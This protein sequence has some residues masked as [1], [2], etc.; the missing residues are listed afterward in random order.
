MGA[1]SRLQSM[2]ESHMRKSTSLGDGKRMPSRDK[3][4]ETKKGT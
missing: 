4:M 1:W 2:R 3:E